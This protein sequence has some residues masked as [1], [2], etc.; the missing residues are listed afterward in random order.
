MI[1]VRVIMNDVV[2]T[3]RAFLP[4]AEFPA[5]AIG[6]LKFGDTL[7]TYQLNLREPQFMS[8]AR[9]IGHLLAVVG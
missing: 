7:K 1:L 8:R 3:V 9:A 6:L 5:V 4:I 2:M